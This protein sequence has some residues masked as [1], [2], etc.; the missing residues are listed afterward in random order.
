MAAI[1]ALVVS[2]DACGVR[3]QADRHGEFSLDPPLPSI[4]PLGRLSCYGL[5]T[6]AEVINEIVTEL[7]VGHPASTRRAPGELPTSKLPTNT[8]HSRAEVAAGTALGWI[9]GL[10]VTVINI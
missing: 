7:P 2:Y 5:R 1:F 6:T 9:I 10:L 8:G 4:S 3:F